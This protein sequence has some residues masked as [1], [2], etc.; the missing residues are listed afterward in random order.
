WR[1]RRRTGQ[2][3]RRASP[4]FCPCCPGSHGSLSGVRTCALVSCALV[5]V[6]TVLR[7]IGSELLTG[8]A[9]ATLLGGPDPSAAEG[10]VSVHFGSITTGNAGASAATSRYVSVPVCEP[11]GCTESSTIVRSGHPDLLVSIDASWV[12]SFG[13]PDMP[14]NSTAKARVG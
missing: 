11:G 9:D 8:A 6:G 13:L 1:W 5:P 10:S 12:G 7:A 14:R 3:S 4:Q 2:R